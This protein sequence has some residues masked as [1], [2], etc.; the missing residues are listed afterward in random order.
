MARLFFPLSF[1]TQIYNISNPT[2][3]DFIIIMIYFGGG[4]KLR[5]LAFMKNLAFVVR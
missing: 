3:T 1:L 4:C 5:S 2:V